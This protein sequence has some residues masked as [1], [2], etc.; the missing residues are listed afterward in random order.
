MSSQFIE[1]PVTSRSFLVRS[2]VCDVGIN[3]ASYVTE[4]SVAGRRERCPFYSVW[5][6]MLGRCYGSNGHPTRPTY[7]GC[8]VC[9]EWLAFSSFKEWM[10]AQQW[11]GNQLDKDIKIKGNK[12]YSPDNCLF[13]P[14]SL[15]SLLTGPT[16]N[17]WLPGVSWN[18]RAKRYAST[19]S[20]KGRPV[21][22]GL[23]PAQEPAHEAYVAAKNAEIERQADLYP[24]WSEYIIQHRLAIRKP[25]KSTK[26]D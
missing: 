3:D 21:H 8:T 18:A 17:K 19:I 9:P 20:I 13:I 5:V 7:A 16:A 25:A 23:H 12:I 10:A 2:K 26:G 1:V 6:A 11:Q 24:Q 14:K 22:L 4:R 15:N